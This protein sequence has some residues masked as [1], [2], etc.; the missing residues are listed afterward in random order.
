MIIIGIGW[1]I[2]NFASLGLLNEA[3]RPSRL[4]LAIHELTLLSVATIGA[5]ETA[6]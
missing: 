2:I 3:A 1:S 6:N 4:M 5:L